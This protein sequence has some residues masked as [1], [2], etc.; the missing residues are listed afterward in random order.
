MYP[1][2]VRGREYTGYFCFTHISGAVSLAKTPATESGPRSVP[3]FHL[4]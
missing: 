2:D 4:L 1:Q 3:G